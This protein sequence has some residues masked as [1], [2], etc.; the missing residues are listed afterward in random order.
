[1]RE[2]ER[3]RTIFFAFCESNLPLRYFHAIY[4]VHNFQFSRIYLAEIHISVHF[5]RFAMSAWLCKYPEYIDEFFLSLWD[6]SCVNFTYL[7]RSH[8]TR[9]FNSSYVFRAFRPGRE[10]GRRERETGTTH[11]DNTYEG[12][13]K[14]IN[15]R[16]TK[17][18]RV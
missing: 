17:H 1:M 12:S 7:I 5:V 6:I 13:Y 2:N 11:Q 15:I 10:R 8:F 14:V 3:G 9:F 16:V 4:I 18:P